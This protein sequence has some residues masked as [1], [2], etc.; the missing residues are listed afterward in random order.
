MAPPPRQ[1]LLSQ[2]GLSKIATLFRTPL[3]ID[4]LS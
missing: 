3:E 1:E 4:L 2:M